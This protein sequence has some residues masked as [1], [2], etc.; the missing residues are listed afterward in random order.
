MSDKTYRNVM[1]DLETMGNGPAAA[2]VAIGAVAFDIEA[3][4][5]GPSYYNRVDLASSVACG[6]VMDASTV[7]WWLNQGDA[8]RLEIARYDGMNIALALQSFAAWM[9]ECAP[10]PEVWGN[11]AS[12]DNVILRGAYERN[13]TPAPWKWWNDRCY[14]T[15]KAMHRDVPMER[16][17][18][19][20][21]AM[22]DAISQARHLITMLNPTK[23]EEA[24]ALSRETESHF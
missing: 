23:R 17:G 18:T 1:L 24:I 16:L 4:E 15:V 9:N 6:G 7:K 5:L 19:H 21:N 3:G 10:D 8:A 12:F 2:I 20:H 13:L 22:A 14:R 11:G